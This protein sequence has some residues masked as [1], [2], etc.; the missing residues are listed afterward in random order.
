MHPALIV[1]AQSVLEGA[2]SE[3]HVVPLTSRIRDYESEVVVEAD[4]QN[5]L[6]NDSAAQCQHLRS[7]SRER[8]VASRGHIGAEVLA[9]VREVIADLLDLPA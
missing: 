4:A 6:D 3:V 2:G 7:V 1:T 5:G 9:Q 8:I